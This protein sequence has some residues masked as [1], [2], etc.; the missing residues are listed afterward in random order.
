[1]GRT[2]PLSQDGKF[3]FLGYLVNIDNHMEYGACAKHVKYTFKTAQKIDSGKIVNAI[4][5]QAIG[6]LYGIQADEVS[7]GNGSEQVFF[8]GRKTCEID[9]V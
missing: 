1:M 5:Q 6:P 3:V 4:K 8:S 2:P 9:T 7:D